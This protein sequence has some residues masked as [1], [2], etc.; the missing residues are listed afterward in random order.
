MALNTES[1]TGLLG[2]HTWRYGNKDGIATFSDINSRQLQFNATSSTG[3]NIEI[4]Q[5]SKSANTFIKERFIFCRTGDSGGN[6][7]YSGNTGDIVNIGDVIGTGKTSAVQGIAVPCSPGLS[8]LTIIE[9]LVTA[10]NSLNCQL[11]AVSGSFIDGFNAADLAT[12]YLVVQLTGIED[13]QPVLAFDQEAPTTPVNAPLMFLNS[14]LDG[15]SSG[16]DGSTAPIKQFSGGSSVLEN[17]YD[18]LITGGLLVNSLTDSDEKQG[19][20]RVNNSLAVISPTQVDNSFQL[21]RARILARSY[22]AYKKKKK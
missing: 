7:G 1:T 6:A 8:A 9:R 2:G 17:F 4:K 10:I 11:P 20:T 14:S 19:L 16:Y 5:F 21:S 22:L 15:Q 12:R 3:D 13:N 18:E